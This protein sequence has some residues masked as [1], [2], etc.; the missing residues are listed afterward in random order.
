MEPKARK[1]ESG[2]ASGARGARTARPRLSTFV[3]FVAVCS[4]TLLTGCE[5]Y[6]RNRWTPDGFSYTVERDRHTGDQADYFGLNWNLK[7]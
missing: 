5:M 1:P 6:S 7:P 2:K 3:L 4:I